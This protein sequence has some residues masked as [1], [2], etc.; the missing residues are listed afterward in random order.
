M[1]LILSGLVITST[2]RTGAVRQSR[3]SGVCGVEWLKDVGWVCI[4][5]RT[6]DL[7]GDLINDRKARQATGVVVS[8]V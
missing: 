4:C 7:V 3:A 1:I 2:H 8:S 5:W 6:E